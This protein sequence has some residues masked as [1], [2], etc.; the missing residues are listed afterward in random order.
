MVIN[1]HCP[2]IAYAPLPIIAAT[3]PLPQ[4]QVQDTAKPTQLPRSQIDTSFGLSEVAIELHKV[5]EF[6]DLNKGG[7]FP[8]AYCSDSFDNFPHCHKLPFNS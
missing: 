7:T 4:H 8:Y 2:G 1:T 5:S 6:L 3:H